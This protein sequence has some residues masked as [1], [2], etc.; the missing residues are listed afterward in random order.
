MANISADHRVSPPNTVCMK[1]SSA[2]HNALHLHV[3]QAEFL[4]A[5]FYISF[6][7]VV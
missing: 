4:C 2:K 7:G 6:C 1:V 5:Q 3:G